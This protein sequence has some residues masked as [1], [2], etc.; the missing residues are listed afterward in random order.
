V[1]SNKHPAARSIAIEITVQGVK[2]FYKTFY[3]N[4]FA[5]N[6]LEL[7]L[8]LGATSYVDSVFFEQVTA[9]G[10]LL[11]TYGGM[12][13]NNNN[14]Y[15]QLVGDAPAGNSYWKAK[16]KLKSGA[17]LYTEI[18][19]VL[20]SGKKY[21]LFYPNPAS[22]NSLLHYTLQQDLPPGTKLLLFD[23]MG[24]LLKDYKEMPGELTS[25]LSLPACLFINYSAAIINCWKQAN[26]LYNNSQ[27]F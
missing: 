24:H 3:Y 25:E 22:G 2:C 7:V 11:Q 18:I 17:V 4:L 21:I 16:I 20:T 13:V 14:T 5:H 12:K 8:E 23:I 1:L 19:T 27:L 6:A 9:G 26:W 15:N 10:Q